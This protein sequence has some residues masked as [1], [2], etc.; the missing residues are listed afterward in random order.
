MRLSSLLIACLLFSACTSKNK[1]TKEL[2]V[3]DVLGEKLM[4]IE[5]SQKLVARLKK[6]DSA[7]T[8]DKPFVDKVKK[9]II[10]SFILDAVVKDYS[11]KNSLK[12]SDPEINAEVDLARKSYPNDLA[13]KESL[14][15]AGLLVEEWRGAIS[16]TL[17][18]KKV[19][20]HVYENTPNK[21][22]I[23]TEEL[24]A[25]YQAHLQEYN[26]PPQV[27]VSQIVIKTLDE[28]QK[29]HK[30]IKAG[31]L[32]FEAAAKKFS[33]S[34]DSQ[35]GGDIG[36]IT[37]GVVPVFDAAFNMNVGVLSSVIKSDYGFHIIKVTA[38]R[39]SSK[40][41]FEQARSGILKVLT[42]EQKAQVFDLWYS[43]HLKE[44]KITQDRPLIENIKI[45][46]QGSFE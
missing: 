3:V 44:V 45:S 32:S 30:S 27:R 46:T 16:K 42:E 28:A 34:P 11:K 22:P 21:K 36:F 29:L 24:K 5:F 41:S 13:F 26:R 15:H 14:A 4:A 25:Y 43:N 35:K 37:K 40:I 17:L 31:K 23:S 10:S 2:A 12:I 18:R 8:K 20:D 33:L 38:R 9:E 6:F 1:Q 19:V 7:S 39:P